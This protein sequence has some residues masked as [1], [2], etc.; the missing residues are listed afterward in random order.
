[1]TKI[2][3][4][5]RADKVMLIEYANG[6][7]YCQHADG[8]QIFT[9]DKGREIRVEKKGFAPVAYSRVEKAEDMEEWLELEKIRSLDGWVT[10]CS[11]PDL[12]KVKTIKF[13][14]DTNNIE[15]VVTKHI[16]LREDFSSFII[17]EE[18]D[19]KVITKTARS[20][21]NNADERTRLGNDTDFLKELYHPST[22]MTPGVFSGKICEDPE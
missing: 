16:Y 12:C 13:F 14:K 9:S 18:G 11:L 1:M 21:I 15:K 7:L 2:V 10:T 19:F 20:S 17:D 22:N 3:T 5:M 8:T 6:D 4:V